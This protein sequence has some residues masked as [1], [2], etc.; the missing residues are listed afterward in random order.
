M[1]YAYVSRCEAGQRRPSVKALRLIAPQLG[2]SVALL[3]TGQ[4]PP[5]DRLLALAGRAL[6]R[7]LV[8]IARIAVRRAQEAL[9]G[10]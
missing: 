5:V 8:G 7:D 4:D 6:D 2:V 1:S 9:S 3:E 10:R